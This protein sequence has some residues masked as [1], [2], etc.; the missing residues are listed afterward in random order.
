MSGSLHLRERSGG[1]HKF[2]S[3]GGNKSRVCSCKKTDLSLNRCCCRPSAS[4][5]TLQELAHLVKSLQLFGLFASAS[6]RIFARG[7]T[8]GA[9]LSVERREKRSIKS[10]LKGYLGIGH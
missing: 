8:S 4:I 2:I 6:K 10:D 7:A 5:S 1:N 9:R 3:K